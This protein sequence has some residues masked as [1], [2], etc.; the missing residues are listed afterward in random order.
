M[1]NLSDFIIISLFL[2]LSLSLHSPE[3]RAG[4]ICP[5]GTYKPRFLTPLIILVILACAV[6]IL[7]FVM[8]HRIAKRNALRSQNLSSQPKKVAIQVK[9]LKGSGESHLQPKLNLQFDRVCVTVKGHDNAA[10]PPSIGDESQPLSTSLPN[11]NGVKTILHDITGTIR[12]G[13]LT[14]VMGPSGSGQTRNT[15]IPRLCDV[16]QHSSYSLLLS[17][18]CSSPII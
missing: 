2:S 5:E 17:Y 18:R 15:H 12:G 10:A 14:A 7:Y 8:H 3:C 9:G 11:S 13:R 1:N 4:E 6:P 16:Y